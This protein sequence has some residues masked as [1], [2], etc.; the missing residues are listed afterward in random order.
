LGSC[1]KLSGIMSDPFQLKSMTAF[2]R[3]VADFAYGRFIVEIQSVNRRFLEINLNLPRQFFRYEIEM[4]KEIAQAVGRGMLN[5]SLSWK[6]GGKE[7][8]TVTP[9]VNLARGLNE[10][11]KKLAQELGIREEIPLTLLA[12]EKEIFL[13]DEEE[14]D[15]AVYQEA[16]FKALRAALDALSHMKTTE[17]T[18]LAQD[19]AKRLILLQ[20]AIHY[21]KEHAKDAPEKYRHKLMARLEEFVSGNLENRERI[22]HEIALFTDRIDMSE[23][24]ARF[25][26]HLAQFESLLHQ[27]YDPRVETRGKTLDFLLQ[28][29]LRESNTIGSKASDANIA[30]HVVSIK[31]ELEKIREQVQN[32]E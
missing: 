32:I 30:Q 13:F 10:A 9:N 17:G 21:I 12:Q 19:L 8:I 3:G 6:K 14:G 20:E 1:G 22:L 7:P 28:E 16:L 29:L 27:S 11:W 2:G 18:H 26:S 5:V 15:Q 31:G 23:E 25:K 24:I 4:R